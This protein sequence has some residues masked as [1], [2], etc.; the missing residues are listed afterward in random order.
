M[1]DP[2]KSGLWEKKTKTCPERKVSVHIISSETLGHQWSK[3]KEW[4]KQADGCLLKP[5]LMIREVGKWLGNGL[6][7]HMSQYVPVKDF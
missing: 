1:Y 2:V 4:R 3:L 6:H 5:I 7:L